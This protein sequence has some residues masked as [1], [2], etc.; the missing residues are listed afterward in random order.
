MLPKAEQMERDRGLTDEQIAANRQ[1]LTQV[2]D[3]EGNRTNPYFDDLRQTVETGVPSP[4][5]TQFQDS[6]LVRVAKHRGLL[7]WGVVGI[8]TLLGY[9]GMPTYHGGG[10][11]W[12]PGAPGALYGLGVGL[13]VQ[14]LTQISYMR[15]RRK[16]GF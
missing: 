4:R 11:L 9:Y 5:L 6:P 10:R 13:G 14:V 15:S 12:D 16:S 1:K 7:R 3:A 2:L 8:F